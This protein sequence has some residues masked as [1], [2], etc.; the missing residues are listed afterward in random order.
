LPAHSLCM[1]FQDSRKT[2]KSIASAEGQQG[3]CFR[4]HML[5]RPTRAAVL[6]PLTSSL[7]VRGALENVSTPMVEI[8]TGWAAAASAACGVQAAW[9][10]AGQV[11]REEADG[12]VRRVLQA[13]VR[14]DRRAG[15][16]MW[17]DRG[18]R[19]QRCL[20]RVLLQ[21]GRLEKQMFSTKNKMDNVDA[22]LQQRMR[23]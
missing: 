8:G 11:L 20:T 19:T 2:L 7:Y 5:S 1:R 10:D 15:G 17:L 13:K 22:V 4:V 9:R 16:G 6:V 18:A 23:R 12:G 21:L 14:H 3:E